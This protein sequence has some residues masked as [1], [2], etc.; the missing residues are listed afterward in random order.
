MRHNFILWLFAALL[1]VL[2][3]GSMA[4]PNQVFESSKLN[5]Q[6]MS[7][8]TAENAKAVDLLKQALAL[9]PESDLIW[10][11]LAVKLNELGRY[12]EALDAIDHATNLGPK[13]ALYW[14]E[15]GI[16][17]NK[18]ERYAD[19]VD[20]FNEVL[21]C[22]DSADYAKSAKEGI[23]YAKSKVTAKLDN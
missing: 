17:L 5:D 19:A 21:R 20:A 16:T 15:K 9:F 11:N 6:A 8:P 1:V 23:H 3:T 12:D 18:L 10:Y 22:D 13:E 2:V 7:L 14:R 4:S